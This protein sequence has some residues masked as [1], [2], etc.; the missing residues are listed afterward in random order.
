MAEV[1]IALGVR[2]ALGDVAGSVAAASATGASSAVGVHAL[3]TRPKM[4]N[5]TRGFTARAS[6]RYNAGAVQDCDEET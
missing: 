1:G 5:E 4:M 2:A 6:L 3:N